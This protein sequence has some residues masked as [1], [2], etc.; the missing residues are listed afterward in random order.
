MLPLRFVSRNWRPSTS[1]PPVS[2][3]CCRRWNLKG[4]ETYGEATWRN[5]KEIRRDVG[6]AMHNYCESYMLGRPVPQVRLGLGRERCVCF[7]GPALTLAAC[8]YAHN[9]FYSLLFLFFLLAYC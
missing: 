1:L 2:A 8:A 3:F 7:H 6:T 5:M 4:I 9:T